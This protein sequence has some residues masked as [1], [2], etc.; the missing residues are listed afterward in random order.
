MST[1]LVYDESGRIKQKMTGPL[2]ACQT[3]LQF[4]GAGLSLLPVSADQ[5]IDGFYVDAGQLMEIPGRP[6]QHH[7]FDFQ[8]K[9]WVDGRSLAQH[10]AAKRA[11]IKAERDKRELYPIGYGNAMLDADLTALRRL[12][13]AISVA[14]SAIASNVPFTQNWTTATN[15]VIVLEA[16]DFVNIELAIAARTATLFDIA[17]NLQA[18]IESA[19]T[20]AEVE[21]IQWPS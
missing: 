1:F 15:S 21:N 10:K 6:S 19:T 3:S 9:Q 2:E 18:Q 20:V 17:R 5:E 12:T 14:K 7:H 13:G 11:E 16:I 4:M 8:T